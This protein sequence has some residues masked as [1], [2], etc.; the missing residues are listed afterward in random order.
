MLYRSI[1]L[2]S[3]RAL[4]F[5]VILALSGVVAP[6]DQLEAASKVT[7][8][9][10][11]IAQEPHLDQIGAVD[12]WQYT[13]GSVRTTIAVIDSGVDVNHPDL[14]DNIWVNPGEVPGDGI[15]NDNNGYIDDVNGWDF[16]NE[17]PDPNPKFSDGY[18]AG[19]IHHGTLIAGLA[20]GVGNNKIGI[21]GVSWRTKIMPLRV[22]NNRGE[23]DALTVARAVDYAVKKKV[24][25]INLSF[26]GEG[27]DPVLKAALER[28]TQAGIVVVAAAGNDE[29]NRVGINLN[30]T[31]LYPVCYSSGNEGVIGVGSLD[32]NDQKANFSHYGKCVD[33]MAPGGDFLTTQMVSYEHTGFDTYYGSGWGG[34]SLSTALVSGSVALLKSV[35]PRLTPHDISRLLSDTCEDVGVLNIKYIGELGCGRI[36]VG[37]AVK[38]AFDEVRA[39][40]IS[41]KVP[42]QTT[43]A[44]ALRGGDG[45]TP[46]V[47]TDSDGEHLK[48]WYPFSPYKIPFSL[49]RSTRGDD[50]FVVGAGAGS[51]S[52]VRIFNKKLQLV[53][54]FFAYDMGF[55]GGVNVAMADVD[56]DGV[57]DIVTAPGP[58]G[59]PQIKVFDVSGVLKYQ[60]FA[61]HPS[62]RFGVQIATGD[63]DGDGIN[64]I[65]STPARDHV[66]DVRVFSAQGILK[67][68]F[69]AYPKA[70]TGSISIA[71]GDLDNDG[72][73]EIVTAPLEGRTPVVKIFS[74]SGIVKKSFAVFDLG[75]TK[76]VSLALIDFNKDNRAEI[77]VAPA[78]VG[79]GPQVRI[80]GPDGGVISQ[81]MAF[82][83]SYRRG[84]MVSA[85]N[86]L[87][88]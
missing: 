74:G 83:P 6:S 81:F 82:L 28:A 87:E 25:V 15:D 26:V 61:Y 51:P 21:A 5:F 46:L 14:H 75:M 62:F 80:F 7:A 17:I 84:L 63:T 42:N 41:T 59:G 49:A 33:I 38:Q 48:E 19:A 39:T 68:Q 60:F 22:L 72:A 86:A 71:V 37:K 69:F 57:E 44:L 35:N 52:Q 27:D 31:P 18:S 85:I 65:I 77:V 4:V 47:F 2:T 24:D 76:G 70:N 3:K 55:R 43:I 45:K 23:G 30:T 20:A 54:Q 13:T 64:E 36:N 58:G 66:S 50:F 40:T 78:G 8:N 34:T 88:L 10:A 1:Y 73:A 29:A 16:I 9:D 12:A 79:A 67:G 56:G 32:A 11:L 53:S